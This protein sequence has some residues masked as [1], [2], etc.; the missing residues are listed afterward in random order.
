M[1]SFPSPSDGPKIYVTTKDGIL[2]T[3]I[4]LNEKVNALMGFDPLFF[5]IK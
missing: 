5:L 2:Y 3:F 1:H 4:N